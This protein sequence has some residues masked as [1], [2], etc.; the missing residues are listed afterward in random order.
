MRALAQV[1]E[2]SML[3]AYEMV[4]ARRLDHMGGDEVSDRFLR[5]LWAHIARL[6]QHRIAHRDLRR[7]NVLAG[8][9]DAPWITGFAF[10]E[11]AAS[12]DQLDGDVA[13][14]LAAVSLTVGAD[15]SVTGAVDTLGP[16]VVGAALPRLQPNAFSDAT[17]AALNGHPGLLEELQDTVAQRCAV[18]EPSYVPLE[19]ISK[20]RIF[21]TA[22]V[23]AVTYFLLPQLADLPGVVR[24]IGAAHWSWVPLVVLFSAFTYVGAA[25]GM[26]GAVPTRLRAVPTLMAQVAA[27][28]ASNL[29]PAGV[30]GMALNVR[31][32]RKSGVDAPVAASSVGLNAAAGFAVHIGLMLVFFL[33]AGRSGFGSISL[34]SWPMV[35]VAVA[36]VAA[37]TAAAL[38]IRASRKMLATRLVPALGSAL[39]GLAAV[40]R[41]PGKIA[42]L[43]GGSAAVTLSYVLAV[44]FSTVAFGGDLNLAQ[45]GAAYLAGSAIAA[46]AP[47]P[48]GLGALEAAVIAGLVGA[49]MPS[50]EAVPAVFLFRLATYWLPILPGWI[51]FNHLRRADFV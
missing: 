50:T 24:E 11:V 37:C 25:L 1:G 9:D 8:T 20:Q 6:R 47:T 15:R 46:A 30:G 2:D 3:I 12:D 41:S 22:M 31:Y 21:T 35:G 4:D 39:R 42:L 14:L 17:R 16:H 38:A 10:S 29:A 44:Y 18:S 34:P 23:A 5:E 36:I 13:Q 43:F 33:W 28:F 40:I 19:R 32:L 51:A 26:G 45:V 49:G 48:G 7:A 27:S